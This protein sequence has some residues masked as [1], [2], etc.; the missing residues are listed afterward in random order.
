MYA[1]AGSP[2]DVAASVSFDVL[3]LRMPP[4]PG[5]SVGYPLHIELPPALFAVTAAAVVLSAVVAAW[6]V[7]REAARKSIV[8]ALAHV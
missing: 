6:A 1:S 2:R 4:P 5:R 8:E 7:S 3:G